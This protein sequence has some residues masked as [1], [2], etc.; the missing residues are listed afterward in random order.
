MLH[1]HFSILRKQTSTKRYLIRRDKDGHNILIKE[2]SQGRRSKILFLYLIYFVLICF[3]VL[4]KPLL[5]SGPRDEKGSRAFTQLPSG[6]RCSFSWRSWTW[7]VQNRKSPFE[8]EEVPQSFRKMRP[9]KSYLFIVGSG[10]LVCVGCG[11]P[12]LHRLVRWFSMFFISLNTSIHSKIYFNAGSSFPRS[13]RDEVLCGQNP[14]NEDPKGLGS[15]LLQDQG[16]F[17]GVLDFATT[18]LEMASAYHERVHGPCI[19]LSRPV[20]PS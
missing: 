9:S 11:S 19:N 18:H 1:I 5:L 20:V 17:R 13:H 14:E 10:R 8:G 4:K 7:L 12:S 15:V 16:S 6:F 2:K 3:S